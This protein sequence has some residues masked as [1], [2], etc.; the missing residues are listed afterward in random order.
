MAPFANRPQAAK[1][2]GSDKSSRW[3][4][5]FKNDVLKKLRN[6]VFTEKHLCQSL[7]LK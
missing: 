1:S 5:F 3:H 4:M 2:L 6:T 7:F